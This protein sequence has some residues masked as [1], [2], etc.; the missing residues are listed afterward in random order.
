MLAPGP[1]GL[2][3]RKHFTLDAGSSITSLPL[4]H[5]GHTSAASFLF[6]SAVLWTLG[7]YHVTK[8]GCAQFMAVFGLGCA[9]ATAFGL[10]DVRKNAH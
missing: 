6:N 4:C 8:Y 2:L 7:H 3:Y 9:A 5:L 10:I 1:M